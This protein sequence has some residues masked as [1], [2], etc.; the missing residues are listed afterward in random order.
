MSAKHFQRLVVK[1]LWEENFRDLL[2]S[3]PEQAMRNFDLT[4]E[5]RA[6]LGRMERER[7]DDLVADYRLR[8][9]KKVLG[10]TAAVAL[11]PQPEPPGKIELDTLFRR[12][13]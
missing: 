10:R 13:G 4:R 2:F 5:E 7:F 11:N 9:T 3:D 6:E 8:L 12:R 1:A